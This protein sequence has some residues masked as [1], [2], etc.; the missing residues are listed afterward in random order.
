[1][2]LLLQETKARP[3]SSVMITISFECIRIKL[4]S[5]PYN[6]KYVD[7]FDKQLMP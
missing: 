4:V 1:M 2:L 6:N 7:N 3:R 5:I